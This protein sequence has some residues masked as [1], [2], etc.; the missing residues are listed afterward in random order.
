MWCWG[1][2]WVGRRWHGWRCP[3]GQLRERRGSNRRSAL[4]IPVL[5]GPR[6]EDDEDAA[7]V[8]KLHRVGVQFRC[9]RR[10]GPHVQ[11]PAG[12]HLALLPQEGQGA[13]GQWPNGAGEIRVGVGR[14][15]RVA[16]LHSDPEPVHGA[17]GVGALQQVVDR[18]L[19]LLRH[20]LQDRPRDRQDLPALG[21]RGWQRRRAQALQ[22][23]VGHDPGRHHLARIHRLRVVRQQRQ[24]LASQCRV[25]QV[26]RRQWGHPKPQLASGVPDHP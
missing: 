23:G 10:S 7:R 16:F 24:C 17:L 12:V 3:R 20:R 9:G 18:L 11:G 21:H 5:P 14:G 2:S 15:A 26:D 13:P 19:R 1:R 4:A 8:A 25:G 22:G 6:T